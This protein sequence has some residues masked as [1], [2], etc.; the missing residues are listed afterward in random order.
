MLTDIRSR[1]PTFPSVLVHRIIEFFLSESTFSEVQSI[2]FSELDTTFH[3]SLARWAFWA[4]DSWDVDEDSEKDFKRDVAATLFTALGPG[5]R[6]TNQD[7]NAATALLQAV[8]AGR[9]DLEAAREILCS[10]HRTQSN[11]NWNHDD[12][13]EM[14]KRLN[15]LL[16]VEIDGDAA[17]VEGPVPQQL[18]YVRP[19][20][21][22]STAPGWRLLDHT[23]AWKPCPIG[24]YVDGSDQF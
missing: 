8:C 21:T 1:H 2:E 19:T 3:M 24:V 14:D 4:I 22:A 20:S 10:S 5:F 23:T 13:T 18:Q 12:V 15:A 17:E 11:R 9:E 16:S 7:Q 6:D